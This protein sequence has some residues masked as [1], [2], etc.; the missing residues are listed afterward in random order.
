[1]ASERGVGGAQRPL[2]CV[3]RHCL[4][5]VLCLCQNRHAQNRELKYGLQL[6]TVSQHYLVSVNQCP[7]LSHDALNEVTTLLIGLSFHY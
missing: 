4:A 5:V 6:L 1:M 7:I 3:T 2:L